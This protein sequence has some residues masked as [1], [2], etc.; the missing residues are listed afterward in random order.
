MVTR[1]ALK[2]EILDPLYLGPTCT[3]EL[4]DEASSY[5]MQ[6]NEQIPQAKR[7]KYPTENPTNPPVP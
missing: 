6:A 1:T 4:V 3:D 5:I 2:V 7:S